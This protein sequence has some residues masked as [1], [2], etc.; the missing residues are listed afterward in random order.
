[1]YVILTIVNLFNLRLCSISHP[2]FAQL[3]CTVSV[4][5]LSKVAIFVPHNDECCSCDFASS[6]SLKYFDLKISVALL[7]SN[8]SLP[9]PVVSLHQ[10][11][12]YSFKALIYMN[13]IDNNHTKKKKK[14]MGR[15]VFIFKCPNNSHNFRTYQLGL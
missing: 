13:K 12:T 15:Q 4:P 9:P 10:Q 3:S 8:I 5:L 1:M 2:L 7:A 11:P 14:K 6:N